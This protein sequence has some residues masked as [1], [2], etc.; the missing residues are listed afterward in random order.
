MRAG[1]GIFH[2]VDL[3]FWNA[4]GNNAHQKLFMSLWARDVFDMALRGICMRGGAGCAA[5]MKKRAPSGNLQWG[6]A[7]MLNK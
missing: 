2:H 3:L 5:P 7:L 1:D 4:P 6:A